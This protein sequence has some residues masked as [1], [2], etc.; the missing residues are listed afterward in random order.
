MANHRVVI[1]G[2]GF[3]GLNAAQSLRSASVEVMLVDRRNFHLF[4]PLLYQVATG[5]LSPSNIA[6]PLRSIVRRQNNCQVLMADVVGF[7]LTN[8]RVHLTNG[9]VPYDS[10]IVAAGAQT[11]YFGNGDWSNRAPGL[12]SIE[13]ALEIRRRILSAFELAEREQDPIRK[14]ALLTFVVV[15]GGPTG[16]ELAGTLAEITRHTLKADFRRC[17][18]ADARILL[19]D[20]APRLLGAMPEDLSTEAQDRLA[21]MQVEVRLNTRVLRLDDAVVTLKE[22]DLTE[23]IA[24]Q[25]ILWAAGVEASPLGQQLTAA[26]GLIAARGG[27]VP[28][29]PQLH[30]EGHPDVFVIG[31]LAHAVDGDGRPFPGVAPVA[32]QQGKYVARLIIARLKNRDLAAFEY[33]D[34]GNM[35][36]IG[37]SAAVAQLGRWKFRGRVAWLMW[38]F[39]H[40][41][42]IVRF[43]NRLLVLIQWAWNYL[44]FNRSAR[45][46]TDVG[47]RESASNT[48][49]PVSSSAPPC[50]P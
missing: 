36:T 24:A 25:T 5:G 20:V 37:R 8:R 11:G 29:G 44:T 31:D 38:L 23:V 40:L 41:M 18:P 30:L 17:Q 35:A 48:E 27:R 9:D 13:D 7:D 49:P 50:S 6:V 47:R 1:V 26:A 22:G 2:G 15:G 16:V 46:I 19:V 28:V 33:F 4:Q 39:I 43:E 21:R 45:L 42:Q 14:T 34:Y 10:L 32:I 12:K 3:G